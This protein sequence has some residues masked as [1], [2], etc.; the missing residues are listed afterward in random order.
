MPMSK[1]SRSRILMTPVDTGLTASAR[2]L[3]DIRVAG[4]RKKSSLLFYYPDTIDGTH[5]EISVGYTRV[6]RPSLKQHTRDQRDHFNE[7]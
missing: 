6:A 1:A 2:E 7:Q 3:R 5:R 4:G